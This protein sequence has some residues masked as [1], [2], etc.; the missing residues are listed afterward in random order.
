MSDETADRR[1]QRA[2]RLSELRTRLDRLDGDEAPD[3]TYD[4][5]SAEFERTGRLPPD[6]PVDHDAMQAQIRQTREQLEKLMR[7]RGMTVDENGWSSP[8]PQPVPVYVSAIERWCGKYA[9]LVLALT[10]PLFVWLVFCAISALVHYGV[11]AV[12]DLSIVAVVI[13]L[14]EAGFG[15]LLAMIWLA[16]FCE[17][18]NIS[19]EQKFRYYRNDLILIAAICG[20]VAVA[21][22][23]SSMVDF[24][25][26]AR[27]WPRFFWRLSF[28]LEAAIVASAIFVAICAAWKKTAFSLRRSLEI[29]I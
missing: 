1:K 21:F 15:A 23:A 12:R 14:L 5:A 18:K 4:P 10:F 28:A 24:V 19:I 16:L 26:D 20:A 9:G 13:G 22:L 25:G 11:V 27:T 8:Q 29:G 2:M 6:A 17:Y 3:P 7:E